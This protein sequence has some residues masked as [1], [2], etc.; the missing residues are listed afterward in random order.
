MVRNGKR[1]F[2]FFRIFKNRSLFR[3]AGITLWFCIYI[4]I[5]DRFCLKSI[6]GLCLYFVLFRPF[7][8]IRS[9]VIAGV[10]VFIG[11]IRERRIFF[12]RYERSRILRNFVLFRNIVEHACE[13][14]FLFGAAS[15]RKMRLHR[16][17]ILCRR[18]CFF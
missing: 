9:I 11:K 7:D 12:L 10:F 14:I 4:F 1:F 6:P 3:T 2:L 15:L 8:F 18:R 17:I 13:R 16:F 5:Y